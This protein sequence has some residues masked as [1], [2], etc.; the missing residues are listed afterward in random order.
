MSEENMK[1]KGASV[2]LGT[3]VLLV[4]LVAICFGGAGYLYGIKGNTATTTTSKTATTSMT[5]S[6]TSSKTA[7][8]SSSSTA[9]NEESLEE[10]ICKQLYPNAK[11]GSMVGTLTVGDQYC[12]VKKISGDFAQGGHNEVADSS[13]GP[14]AAWMAAKLGGK[15]ENVTTTQDTWDCVVLKKYNVPKDLLDNNGKCFNYDT[16]KEEDY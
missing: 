15:W 9:L 12:S 3:F 16:Q 6:A 8:V 13:G 11:Y 7:V 2:R 4:I 10:A 1:S 5:V 14:G